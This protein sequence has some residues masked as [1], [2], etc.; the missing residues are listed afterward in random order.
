M[1][2]ASARPATNQGNGGGLFNSRR[3]MHYKIPAIPRA[4]LSGFDQHV[5]RIDL[6]WKECA[7]RPGW[8]WPPNICG[9]RISC[10]SSSTVDPHAGVGGQLEQLEMLVAEAEAFSGPTLI[11]GDF[12]TLSKKKVD[13]TREFLESHGYTTPFPSGT[14]TWRGAGL[15]LHADWIFGRDVEITKWGWAGHEVRTLAIWRKY[16]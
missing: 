15:R 2:P 8:R 9:G 7:W 14:P 13:E 5:T 10:A 11:L 12:N 1:P 3:K 4:V 16:G 6:P